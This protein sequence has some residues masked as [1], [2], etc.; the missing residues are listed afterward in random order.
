MPKNLKRVVADDVIQP[1]PLSSSDG[2][3]PINLPPVEVKAGESVVW[4]DW[5][6]ARLPE[7]WGE[8]C[9]EYR[10]ERFY[11]AEKNSCREFSQWKFH[12]FNGGP[13]VCLGKTLA[14]YEG[15]SVVAA[16]LGR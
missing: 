2:L 3:P 12:A 13:R 1:V 4:S 15:M 16:I 14:V 6:M 11:D 10:P 7:V 9:A 5:T 8:D